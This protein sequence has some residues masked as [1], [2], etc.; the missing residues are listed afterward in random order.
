M[1][2]VSAHPILFHFNGLIFR[3]SAH[4]FSIR[5]CK[6]KTRVYVGCSSSSHV[7]DLMYMGKVN[8]DCIY[9]ALY[10]IFIME[11]HIQLHAQF[12]L[13]NIAQ[14]LMFPLQDGD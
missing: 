1:D 9:E 6:L 11:S 5:G 4:F 7:H 13:T 14:T 8:P 2:Q 3:F 12:F 10:S